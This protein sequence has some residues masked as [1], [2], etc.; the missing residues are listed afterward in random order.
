MLV[1]DR[2]G[3]NADG[4]VACINRPALQRALGEGDQALVAVELHRSQVVAGAEGN[5][6]PVLVGSQVQ[7]LVARIHLQSLGGDEGRPG[8]EGAGVS[9]AALLVIPKAAA[10]KLVIVGTP[11]DGVGDVLQSYREGQGGDGVS[12]ARPDGGN[13]GVVVGVQADKATLGAGGVDQA[14]VGIAEA[15]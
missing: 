2:W 15:R 11:D 9:G 13:L 14:E 12:D 7:G 5:R 1:G 4:S 10:P 3:L 8:G 6:D